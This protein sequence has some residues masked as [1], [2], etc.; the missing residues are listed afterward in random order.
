M[1]VDLGGLSATNL[2]SHNTVITEN[3]SPRNSIISSIRNTQNLMILDSQVPVIL[4]KW[5]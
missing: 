1:K 3:M 4:T 2:V 5:P